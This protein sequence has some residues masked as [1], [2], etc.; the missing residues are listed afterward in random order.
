MAI[1]L[2]MPEKVV[3]LAVLKGKPP[4]W[5]WWILSQGIH[6]VAKVFIVVLKLIVDC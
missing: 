1:V 3:A 4:N 2:Q 6:L 5:Y